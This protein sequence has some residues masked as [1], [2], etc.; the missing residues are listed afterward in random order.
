MLRE[1]L[2]KLEQ[3]VERLRNDNKNLEDREHEA[4]DEVRQHANKI[5]LLN[6]ELE[7]ARAEIDALRSKCHSS[8]RVE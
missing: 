6:K 3:D 4:R 2:K 5:H 1:K 8:Q 7:D